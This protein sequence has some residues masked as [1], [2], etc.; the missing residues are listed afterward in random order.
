M[1]LWLGS[2]IV[3]G[4]GYLFDKFVTPDWAKGPNHSDNKGG[5]VKP[6]KS[7]PW[8][9]VLSVI[10]STLSIFLWYF[11]L[12]RKPAIA[13]DRLDYYKG[14]LGLSDAEVAGKSKA[15]LAGLLKRKKEE[16]FALSKDIATDLPVQN[17]TIT[18]GRGFGGRG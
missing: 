4:A 14:A 2:A 11:F 12:R 15:F 1:W 6:G 18:R 13:D 7:F 3:V 10:G 8:G 5:G 9:T 17:V 16:K